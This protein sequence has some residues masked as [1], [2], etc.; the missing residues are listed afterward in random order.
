MEIKYDKQADARYIRLRKGNI[1][2][3]KKEKDWLLFDLDKEGN[4][5]GI[6]VLNASKN[7]VGLSVI[8]NILFSLFTTIPVEDKYRDIGEI[9]AIDR[10]AYQKDFLFSE[11]K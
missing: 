1:D 6:E 8:G 11:V 10:W 4:I 2:R 3:T 5:L 7:L 9:K